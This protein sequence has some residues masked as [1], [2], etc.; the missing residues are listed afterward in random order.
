VLAA[1]E[2]ERVTAQ[3]RSAVP[4][5][6]L[7]APIAGLPCG[8]LQDASPDGL[9]TAVRG[10]AIRHLGSAEQVYDNVFI[11]SVRSLR[12]VYNDYA[13]AQVHLLTSIRAIPDEQL[14]SWQ[15]YLTRLAGEGLSA[16]HIPSNSWPHII[17]DLHAAGVPVPPDW[18]PM[19]R[20]TFMRVVANALRREADKE[21]AEYTTNRFQQVLA[22]GLD[23]DSFCNEA[24][25]QTR[26][27]AM[28]GAPADAKLSPNMGF[29]A[30]RSIA[31]EPQVDSF[32]A[33]YLNDLLSSP[34]T[35]MPANRLGLA[36]T[37]AVTWAVAP[38]VLFYITALCIFWHVPR[39]LS[40]VCRILMP[41]V[42]SPMRR[43]ASIGCL[44]VVVLASAS[45]PVPPPAT[46]FDTAQGAQIHD[47]DRPPLK[48]FWTFASGLRQLVFL[49]FG[50]G[51]DDSIA[52]E[53][54]EL[55]K[56]LL[57]PEG[58]TS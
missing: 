2:Q 42:G 24:T 4:V 55:L 39:L 44:L 12:D 27:R 34:D 7:G 18:N 50:F 28:I 41:R 57:H 19:D 40:F 25:I 31:Y 10:M 21:Y 20:A 49:G 1:A 14:R 52:G 23:W 6:L 46:T 51:Y 16:N 13:A 26:W 17:A 53:G 9:T 3:P 11:P 32:A 8:E 56:S 35:F 38:S 58:S 15:Q 29:Q 47:V 30:F 48:L 43:T 54:G 36:G 37:A 45:W 33:P 22:P 5:I